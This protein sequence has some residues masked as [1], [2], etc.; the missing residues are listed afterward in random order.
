M[1]GL[2]KEPGMSEALEFLAALR[3]NGPWTL[4]AI[5][6][7]KVPTRTCRTLREAGEF[8]AQYADRNLYYQ[9]NPTKPVSRKARLTDLT[10]LEFAHVDIDHDAGGAAYV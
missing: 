8:I 5:A 9:P 4:S 6:A 7:G 10:A 1:A 3:R 2:D